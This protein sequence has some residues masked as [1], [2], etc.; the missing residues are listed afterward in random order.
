M[1]KLRS[2]LCDDDQQII[3]TV[4]GYGYRLAVG[5]SFR[6][7]ATSNGIWLPRAGETMPA[8]PNWRFSGELRGGGFGQVWLAEQTKTHEQ[9]V[10]KFAADGAELHALK[11]EITLY[12]LLHDSLGDHAPIVR[13]IDWNV[14]E[15]PYFTEAEYLADGNLVEWCERRGGAPRLRAPSSRDRGAHCRS[16]AA[17]PVGVLHKDLKPGNVLLVDGESPTPACACSISAASRSSLTPDGARHYP[18]GSDQTRA[19]GD[20]TSGTPYYLAPEVIAGKAV[21][22]R[23]DIYALGVILYQFLVGDFR[24]PL[25]PGWERDVDDE[26]LRE[27]V[28]AAAD[29]DPER[30]LGD[31]AEL[32]RRLRDLPERAAQRLKERSE[33]QARQRHEVELMRWRAP[34]L[35]GGP[36]GRWR[37]PRQQSHRCICASS[38]KRQS[39][40]PE[41]FS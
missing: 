13:I 19:A 17:A 27:D 18:A 10:F 6:A 9:R 23:A 34:P 28:A 22:V 40:R 4:H 32:A 14:D 31:A 25:A 35:V 2:A 5:V 7:A 8:R 1:T 38:A 41:Q 33:A 16:L 12:R 21:T 26:L 30:R 37:P 24:A 15:P 11:R 3:R 36:V 29:V 39:S 20:T